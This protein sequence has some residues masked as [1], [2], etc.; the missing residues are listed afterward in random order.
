MRLKLAAVSL[1]ALSLAIS[2]GAQAQNAADPAAQAAAATTGEPA[3]VSELIESVSIPYEQ[4]QLDNGLT[5]LVHED[6]KAP[7]VGVSVWYEIG[8]KHEPKGKTGFAHLFE[9]L[10]FNGSENAPGDFFEPLQQVGATDFNGTTWFDRTNY[11]ETVPTGALDLA[12]MLES[13]RM[14]HLLGAVTQEKLDNQIGVVQN[15]KRQ[16]DN[17][18]YGLVEYE[19]LENLYPSGHPYHHSTIGSMADLSGATMA[20]VQ[21]WFRDHYGPNNAVLVLAGDIDTATAREKVTKWFGA[22]PA[23]PEIKAV[24]APVPTLPAPLSK[25]I[26]DRIASPR[27]YRMWAVPGLDNPEYLPLSMGA[28]VLGGLASS[29][30]DN[31]LVREQQLAVRVVASAQIFA[32]AG[33]FVVYADAKPGVSQ[34]QLAAALDAEIAKFVAE[35][36]TADELQRAVTTYAAGQIRGLEQVGGFSGKAP[37]LAEGLLYSGNPAEY[38]EVLETAAAMTPERVRDVTAKWL[39]R[40]VFKLTVEPGERKEGGEARGG[41]FTGAGDSGLAGPAFY[42]SPLSMQAGA[43]AAEVDRSTLPEVG[44]LK[45]LDF[46]DIQRATLSNGMEVYFAQ[47]DAVPTV[48][49]RVNF[50]AGYAADPKD[51]LGVQSLMLSMMDEGTTSLDSNALAI[52]KERLGAN[53]YTY[54]DMDTTAVGLDAMAPNLAPSLELMADYIR[55]PAFDPEELERVRAQQLTRIQNE[56]NSPG[57]IAQRALAPV[58]FGDAHPYGIPP[59]GTGNPDVVASLTAPELRAFHDTWLRPDLAR[60]FVVGD[61]TLAETTRLLEAA[62]GNWQAPATPAPEKNF[63]V[64]VPAQESRIILIDRPNSPQS[65]ILAGHVLEQ[66]GT[67]DLLVLDAANE[68]FGGSFLSRINMNLR[69]T[70]GWSYGVRSMV[71]Q[72]LDRSSFMIYAPVQADRTGDSIVELR[73]ELAAYTDDGK[74]VTEEE[75]T[76]LINGNVRELPGQFETSGDVLGGIVEIVTYGRPDDYYETLSGRYSALTSAEIDAKAVET[77]EGSDLVFVVVGDAD[78]VRPQLETLGLPIEVREAETSPSE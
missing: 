70:K 20:D 49:V 31:A 23:G 38:K 29:R 75:L 57:A 27:L 35:G 37:T 42:S 21:S 26:Y 25:T 52:A 63:E 32:Q 62:F 46:P 51:K 48:S 7:V 9:H 22:I 3:P 11:F 60:I 24:A 68:V 4:F 10:M 74:G 45:P 71:Q 28:T 66:K 50:D 77:L 76:R 40:P 17:Q 16:G 15:E 64:A 39:S 56:L 8:S 61:T 2:T 78:V 53:L 36:P 69:E 34:E 6:R 41:Y 14:G 43:A 33:Q 54:A 67:D 30:L 47:R 13:D 44:E 58:L 19:Q 72:P 55:N 1:A 5:V 12:L 73:K 65:V 18:P 59:S